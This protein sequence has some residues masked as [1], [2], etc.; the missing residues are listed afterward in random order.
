[1]RDFGHTFV[2]GFD[3][4]QFK[5]RLKLIHENEYLLAMKTPI[6]N[7]FNRLKQ[8]SVDKSVDNG[9]FHNMEVHLEFYI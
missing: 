7:L 8:R 2:F 4:I 9:I 6:C 5:N 3:F 1:M